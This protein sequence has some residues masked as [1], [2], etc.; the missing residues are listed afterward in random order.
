MSYLQKK[1]INGHTYYYYTE[2]KRINGKPTKVQ[3][4]YL[5]NAD[6]VFEKCTSTETPDPPVKT[7]HL[8]FGLAAALYEEALELGLIPMINSYATFSSPRLDVGQYLVLAAI[9][10]VCDPKSKNGIGAWYNKSMLPSLFT[11][12]VNRATGQRFWDAMDCFPV[13]AIPCVEEDLWGKTMEHFGM[14]LDWLIYDTTNFFS[15]LAEQTPSELYEKGNNK[16]FRH[17]LRQ[18]GMAV[19]VVRGLGL[20]LIH[21]LYGGS[22]HDAPLFASAISHTIDRVRKL[23]HDQIDDLTVVFDKGNNS[24]ENI[25]GLASAKVHFIGSLSPSNYPE[26][27]SIRLSRFNEA[28]LENGRKIS[29]FE[30]T[31]NAFERSMR[32]VIVYNEAAA[33]KKEKRFQKDLGKALAELNQVRWAKVKDPEAKIAQVVSPK[34]PGYLFKSEGSGAHLKVGL[35][36]TAVTQYRKRFGKTLVFTDRKDLTTL[37]VAQAYTDRGEIEGLFGEMNDPMVC[38][39]RPVRHW[40]DQKIAVHAFICILGLLLLKLLQLKL[41]KQGITLSLELIKDELESIQM[42]L[43]IARSGKLFK[44]ISDRSKLQAKMFCILSLQNV[45][46]LLG[47]QVDDS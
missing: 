20:P 44:I 35:D 25:N 36:Q 11:I 42:G 19:S 2:A 47:A 12:P 28:T 31:A 24:E 18:V 32:V 21:E 7:S 23:S 8:E 43:W 40:T 38:P 45:A 30:T 27:C 5:G 26:L 6:Q 46:S 9:N 17:H 34:L 1:R 10:R 13:K 3:Q 14:P 41:K 16:A 39:F 4:V 22:Q 15:F 29:L 37:D 33:R